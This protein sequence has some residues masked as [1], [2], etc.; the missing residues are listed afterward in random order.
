[1]Q[2][3]LRVLGDAGMVQLERQ[4]IMVQLQRQEM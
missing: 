3:S 4:E 2:L 1:M